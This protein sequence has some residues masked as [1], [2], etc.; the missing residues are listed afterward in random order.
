MARGNP[1][2]SSDTSDVPTR[3]RLM[4]VDDHEVLRMGLRALLSDFDDFEICAETG[5]ASEA[6]PLTEKHRPDVI[7]LDLKLKE[8][9]GA[10]VC[11]KLKTLDPCPQVLALTAHSDR[12]HVL[13]AIEAGVDG[14]LLKDMNRDQ[15]AKAVRMVSE[16]KTFLDPAITHHLITQIQ[17]Q[18]SQGREQELFKSLSLQE[19]RV[20]AG[21][22]EG[23]TN[24]EIALELNLS[25]K[26]VKNYL[27][28]AMDKLG[29]HRRA[30]AAAFFVRN[31]SEQDPVS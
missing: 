10:L 15:L 26:T 8:D 4:I 6:L 30:Q 29:V 11:K 5:N 3:I 25:D 28:N 14:Y 17:T 23:W 27:S 21:V 9:N 31:Q 22:S 16:G 2:K 24:K 18:K 7:L 19:K 13:E 12:E 1:E 20:L